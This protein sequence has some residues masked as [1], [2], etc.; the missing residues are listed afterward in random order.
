MTN[1]SHSIWYVLPNLLQAFSH[2]TFER[3]G[4][5]LIVVDIQGVGDLY[6]DP[7]IHTHNGTGYGD[8][9]LGT[10]GVALF[11]Y[12]HVCNSICS[13]LALSQFDLADSE[14]AIQKKYIDFQVSCGPNILNS[15]ISFIKIQPELS[16]PISFLGIE[17][18]WPGRN[19][20]VT[21]EG[22]MGSIQRPKLRRI[23][24]MTNHYTTLTHS[25]TNISKTNRTHTK[26]FTN[27]YMFEPFIWDVFSMFTYYQKRHLKYN[28]IWHKL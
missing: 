18:C 28:E 24:P 16:R 4:H 23:E 27:N 19:K 14:V 10:R 5:Q 9:N 21:W 3:S 1:L 11:F 6:T 8:G 20:K 17:D 22:W 12:S 7:Q 25:L 13:S 2:F 15:V 26:H